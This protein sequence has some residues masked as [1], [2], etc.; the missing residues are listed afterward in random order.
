[1]IKRFY[2]EVS[3][4][5]HPLSPTKHSESRVVRENL[6]F[7]QKNKSEQYFGILLDKKLAKTFYKNDMMIPSYDL[8]LAIAEEWEI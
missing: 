5:K 8:A 4:I 6:L 7:G 3:I 2:K 1:M